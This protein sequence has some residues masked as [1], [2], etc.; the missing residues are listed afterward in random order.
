LTKTHGQI[1]QEKA[2]TVPEQLLSNKN[3]KHQTALKFIA[4]NTTNAQRG[5][6]YE[7]LPQI[8]KR[9]MKII[10]DSLPGQQGDPGR[11]G[12]DNRRFIE[13]VMRIARPGVPWR[14]LPPEYGK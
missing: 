1:R 3:I 14:D 6:A 5:V 7:T 8:S 13:A 10:K 11:T 2:E 9:S 12:D 4:L